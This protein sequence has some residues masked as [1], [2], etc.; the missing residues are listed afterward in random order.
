[1]EETQLGLF[2]GRK[3]DQHEGMG[4]GARVQGVSIMKRERESARAR[5]RERERER[6][7]AQT[8][9]NDDRCARARLRTYLRLCTVL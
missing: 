4:G 3:E 5:E 9:A 1:M 8:H 6:D 7:R 2:V